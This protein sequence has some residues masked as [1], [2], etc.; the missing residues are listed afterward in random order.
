MEPIK[1]TMKDKK[2]LNH[3]AAVEK[4]IAKKYGKEAVQNP[5]ANWNDEK[6]KDYLE[7]IK[8]VSKKLR[9]A[10]EYAEKV[11][12]NG[13]LVSKKLLNKESTNSC[14]VCD[15]YCFKAK[16]DV[17][18]IKYECCFNCYTQWVEWREVRWLQGWRPD[19]NNDKTNS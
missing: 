12:M 15:K 17:Y 8:E 18:M 13:V 7:Q 2:D 14:P 11:E 5:R 6:E 16:D 1:Y 3:I 9:K 10:E 19:A 4:A